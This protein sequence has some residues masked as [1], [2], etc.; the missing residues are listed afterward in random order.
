MII[1]KGAKTH[2]VSGV[3]MPGGVSKCGDLRAGPSM[4]QQVPLF[5]VLSDVELERLLKWVAIRAFSKGEVIVGQAPVRDE[6]YFLLHGQLQVLGRL[7]DGRDFSL[8]TVVPGGFFG[9]LGVIDALPPS[10]AVVALKPSR[11]GVLPGEQA[12]E[13]FCQVPAVAELMLRHLTRMLRQ[14]NAFR[15]LLGMPNAPQRV[16]GF[17]CMLRQPQAGGVQVIE[18]MPSQQDVANMINTSRESVSRTLSDLLR[19][20]VLEKGGGKYIVRQP[21]VLEALAHGMPVRAL[22]VEMAA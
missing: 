13:L 8:G 20:G 12:R 22:R 3:H 2:A 19:R 15:V 1:E 9:E 6:L 14:S 11:V 10:V 16:Y 17:L 4:L 18:T 5:A 7:E 21:D